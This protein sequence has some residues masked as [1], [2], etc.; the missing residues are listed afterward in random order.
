[1]G[2][3]PRVRSHRSREDGALQAYEYGHLAFERGER[4]SGGY[5]S[6]WEYDE[7]DRAGYAGGGRYEPYCQRGQVGGG[8][9]AEDEEFAAWVA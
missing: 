3:H 8:Y 4:E 6:Q 1:M 2:F 9:G 5:G 7:A